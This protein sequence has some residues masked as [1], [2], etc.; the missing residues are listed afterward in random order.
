M[1]KTAIYIR[2]STEKQVQEGDSIPAQRN[3]LVKYINDHNDM[4]LTAEYVDDGVSGTRDD[5]TE[6][7]KMLQDVKDGSIDVIL[8]TKLD[9]LHRSLKNFL[10]MQEILD[11]NNCNWTAIWEPIYDG[12]TPQGS[13]PDC[14]CPHR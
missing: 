7:Q 8:V 12:S 1:K 11:K 4:I 13:C 2:V 10:S 14:F 5:R 3:A 6:F 9:R